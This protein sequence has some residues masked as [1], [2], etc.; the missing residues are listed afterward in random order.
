MGE[1]FER[2]DIFEGDVFAEGDEFMFIVSALDISVGGEDIDGVME[3]SLLVILELG[4]SAGD[5]GAVGWDL[6]CECAADSWGLVEWPYDSGFGED[7]VCEVLILGDEVCLCAEVLG[8]NIWEPF[9]LLWDIGLD[10]TELDLV[11]VLG[12]SEKS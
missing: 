4:D 9:I 10:D 5:E 11:E 3:G 6:V 12:W 1:F 7:G 2:R 8:S